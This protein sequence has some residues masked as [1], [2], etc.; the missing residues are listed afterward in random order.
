MALAWGAA[1]EAAGDDPICGV[2]AAVIATAFMILVPSP[3]EPPGGLSMN[4]GSHASA[5]QGCSSTKV[6]W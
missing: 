3:P 5:Q 2:V 4:R 6:P 1:Y